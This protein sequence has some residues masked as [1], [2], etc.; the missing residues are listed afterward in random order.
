MVDLS[1]GYCDKL[2]QRTIATPAHDS[3]GNYPLHHHVCHPRGCRG[4]FLLTARLLR[5]FTCKALAIETP[6]S[7]LQLAG[8]I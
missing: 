7:L 2:Q 5:G 8:G 4:V 3:E 1:G 6:L